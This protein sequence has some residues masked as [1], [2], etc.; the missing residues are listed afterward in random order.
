[1]PASSVPILNVLEPFAT[2]ARQEGG[3]ALYDRLQEALET[4]VGP[5]DALRDAGVP[6]ARILEALARHHGLQAVSYDERLSVA[7][8]LVA[9]IDYALLADGRWFPLAMDAEGQVVVALSDPDDEETRQ[10]AA[11]HFPGHPMRWRVA[12]AE[13]I[14]WFAEDFLRRSSGAQ[15]GTERTALAL[16]RN[17]MAHWR[18]RMAGYRT[19]MAKARTSLNVLRWGLGLVALSNSMYRARTLGDHAA[20]YLLGAAAGLA[21]AGACLWSYLKLR[22][23]P[24]APPGTQTLVEVTAATLQFLEAFHYIE[25]HQP[26]RAHEAVAEAKPTMLGRLADML[27]G[28]STILDMT[29]VAGV[30]V[31]LARERN[32]LAAQRTVCACYRTIAARARTGL[33]LLRTGVSVAGLGL[34]LMGYFGLSLLSALDALL[35]LAGLLMIADGLAWYWPVRREY[36]ETPRCVEWDSD[37]D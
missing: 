3:E 18:T 34:G 33:A 20:L 27:C 12:L 15:V 16:W 31:H 4:G 11:R 7:P 6:K 24:L 23:P 9:E 8:E 36:A 37:E 29:V 35:V 22:R 25:G 10:E 5:V 28:H 17:T 26:P 1:M 32:V 30:R 13:D 2:L 21:V 14:R 19:D